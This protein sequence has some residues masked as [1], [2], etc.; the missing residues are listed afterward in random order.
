[1]WPR[2]W[3]SDVCSSDL[4]GDHPHERRARPAREDDRRPRGGR[5][6]RAR[7]HGCEPVAR[8]DRALAA[9]R[10]REGGGAGEAGARGAALALRRR[11]GREDHAREG[12]AS[13]SR[14]VADDERRRAGLIAA[15]VLLLLLIVV[16][17]LVTA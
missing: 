1:R 3:S 11:E 8:R 7:A 12:S 6:P 14:S 2:D 17:T 13:R 10:L 9:H 4:L 5:G 16:A 15:E